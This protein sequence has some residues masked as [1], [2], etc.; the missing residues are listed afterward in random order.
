MCS[1]SI[2]EVLKY[3]KFFLTHILMLK[4]V[5]ESENRHIISIGETPSVAKLYRYTNIL[6]EYNMVGT[7]FV[8]ENYNITITVIL[9]IY[10]S[11]SILFSLS[12][13]TV[14]TWEMMLP[15]YGGE[16]Y[17]CS[18]RSFDGNGTDVRNIF[19]Y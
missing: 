7:L 12:D 6:W 15:V 17:F 5:L 13:I 11:C 9:T 1:T 2:N 10:K 16:R 4:N 8:V 3:E 19:S 18:V 14:D